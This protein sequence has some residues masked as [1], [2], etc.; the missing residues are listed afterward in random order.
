[1]GTEIIDV[2]IEVIERLRLVKIEESIIDDL[3][4]AI[5]KQ[6]KKRIMQR[7]AEELDM[8]LKE[9]YPYLQIKA[10]CGWGDFIQIT[11]DN[12]SADLPVLKELMQSLTPKKWNNNSISPDRMEFVATLFI[13]QDYDA[14]YCR[15]KFIDIWRDGMLTSV[16]ISSNVPD[17]CDVVEEEQTIKS[18]RLVGFCKELT[19]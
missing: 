14:V 7:F 6:I 10:Y 5:A 9:K 17:K 18:Y 3:K 11:I 1:M 16:Y 12:L 15:A 13:P 4:D 8:K 19:K 2:A